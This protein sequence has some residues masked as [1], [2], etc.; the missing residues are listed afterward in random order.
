MRRSLP[1]AL[2]QVLRPALPGVGEAI[3]DAIREE[4][5]DYARPLTGTFQMPVVTRCPRHSTVRTAPTL[6]DSIS[7]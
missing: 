1:P 5:P 3:I 2:T 7:P 6:M 4:V